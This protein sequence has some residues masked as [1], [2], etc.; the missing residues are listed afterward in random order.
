MG[1][2]WNG[3]KARF[4]SLPKLRLALSAGLV[5]G[6]TYIEALGGEKD[7]LLIKVGGAI[8]IIGGACVIESNTDRPKQNN[9]DGE[10]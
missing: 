3:F 6:G 4:D 1:E 10:L 8:L 7:S 5:S 2:R 9:S